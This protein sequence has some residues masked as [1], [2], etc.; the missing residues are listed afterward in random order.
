MVRRPLA[1][2]IFVVGGWS[3]QMYPAC[4]WSQAPGHNGVRASLVYK[5]GRTQKG[6]HSH[7]GLGNAGCDRSLTH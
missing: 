5:V 3:A 4:L 2:E 1:S 6:S 7:A